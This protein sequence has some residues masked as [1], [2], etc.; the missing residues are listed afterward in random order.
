MTTA[1]PWRIYFVS[2]AVKAATG[3][4][5]TLYAHA[6]ALR[7]AGF[8]AVVVQTRADYRPRWFEPTVPI[9]GLD[10]ASPQPHDVVVVPEDHAAGL[11]WARRQAARR[12]VFCQNHFFAAAILDEATDWMRDGF[13]VLCASE[14]VR[15]FLARHYGWRDLPVVPCAVDGSL[16]RPR[17]K[18]RLIV[19]M[20]RKRPVEASMIR[21]LFRR[22]F[23][24]HADVAFEPIE[25]MSEAETAER[26][27]RAEIFLALG[28]F[29]GFGLPPLEAMAADALVVGFHGEGGR[30]YA[31]AENGIWFDEGAVEP[32]I[33][34]LG[35][36]CDR[37][38]A[39]DPTVPA[40]RAAGRATVARC[41]IAARDAAL[42]RFW[43]T[44]APAG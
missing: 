8:D 17:A 10:G 6:T 9:V 42:L 40:M 37:V 22:R 18:E 7:E 23:P 12:L 19:F 14:A 15:A 27:G 29:E 28:R 20:P 39:G 38:K 31:T 25:G 34:A 11:A 2:P 16:F 24:R 26:L 30:E 21:L 13:G 44:M 43:H 35:A 1:R 32:C 5:R 3:G 33:D 36:I 4:V 41:S